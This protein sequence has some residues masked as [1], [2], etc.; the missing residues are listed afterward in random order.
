MSDRPILF[1]GPMVNALLE[2]R[3]TQTRRV[4]NPQ[5]EPLGPEYQCDWRMHKGRAVFNFTNEQMARGLASSLVPY[6]VGDRLWVR[7]AWRTPESLDHLSPTQ[8]AAQCKEA[9]Y[10]G[11]WCPRLT[12]ADDMTHQWSEEDGF[13]DDEPAGRFRQGM[14]MP[15]WAS[16]L[17]LPVTDVRVQRLQDI[18]E[19]DAIAE[20]IARTIDSYGNG[21]SY[22]DYFLG[23]NSDMA[24]WFR[25]PLDSFQSLWDSINAKRDGGK[26]AWEANP[27]VVAPTFEIVRSNIDVIEVAA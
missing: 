26:Y 19:E 25:S 2:G 22:C 1:S 16:R 10:H 14:H 17:T 24:E 4:L 13:R 21:P 3:K 6:A 5:P 7:E 8:I 9:G 23:E 18:S 12:I 11:V 20:G 27:W 15:R